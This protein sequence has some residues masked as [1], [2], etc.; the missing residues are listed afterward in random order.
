MTTWFVWFL[1]AE[2]KQRGRLIIDQLVVLFKKNSAQN[3]SH[4]MWYELEISVSTSNI[5]G[6]APLCAKLTIKAFI[7][8]ICKQLLSPL[9][10]IITFFIGGGDKQFLPNCQVSSVTH[11]SFMLF[12]PSWFNSQVYDY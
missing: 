4:Q 12:V 8:L 3:N 6:C 1:V 5:H 2:Y 10:F 11:F 7:Y 9:T